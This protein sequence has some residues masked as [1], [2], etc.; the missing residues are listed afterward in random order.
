LK[1][2]LDLSQGGEIGTKMSD[3]FVMPVGAT[4]RGDPHLTCPASFNNPSLFQR[5]GELI[6]HLTPKM[7]LE[8]L[9]QVQNDNYQGIIH[10]N[11][12]LNLF[13]HLV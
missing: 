2:V 12:M 5:G 10:K 1:A 7:Q 4:P 13:Q 6:N 11:V 8:I 9:K 3:I